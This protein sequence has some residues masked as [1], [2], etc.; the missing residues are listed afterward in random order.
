M[1]WSKRPGVAVAIVAA[2]HA[3]SDHG[4]AAPKGRNEIARGKRQHSPG[5]TRAKKGVLKGRDEARGIFR[6]RAFLF[7]PMRVTP[8]WGSSIC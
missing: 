6:P 5:F 8:F 2:A 1:D 7:G 3:R 4:F